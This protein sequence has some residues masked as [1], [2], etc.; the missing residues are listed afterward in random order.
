MEQ[1][2]ACLATVGRP[3]IKYFNLGRQISWGPL[4]MCLSKY[5]FSKGSTLGS[6]ASKILF[7]QHCTSRES[8]LK[9]D[10]Q[11]TKDQIQL[12]SDS[13]EYSLATLPFASRH[14]NP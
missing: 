13:E 2:L 8:S 12:L 1:H 7:Y 4:E 9:T 5:L 10:H 11:V 6:K 14:Y 3:G